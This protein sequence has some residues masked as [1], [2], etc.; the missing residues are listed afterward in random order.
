MTVNII[1]F[2]LALIMAQAQAQAQTNP[3]L[4]CLGR[5]EALFHKGKRQGPI[6][7]LNQRIITEIAGRNLQL[8]D[9]YFKQVCGGKERHPSVALFRLLLL[10]GE[11]IFKKQAVSLSIE[12]LPHLFINYL[13][14]WQALAPKA[15]CLTKAIPELA[16]LIQRFKYLQEELSPWEVLSDKK[17]I[18][19]IFDKLENFDRIA[20]SCK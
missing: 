8:K 10:E 5:E 15:P 19:R 16:P 3:L 18:A 1:P 14:Q 6:Y 7:H 11:K 17:S 13:M 4:Y 2:L 20:A 12:G 9:R